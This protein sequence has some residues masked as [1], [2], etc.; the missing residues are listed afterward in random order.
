MSRHWVRSFALR[1]GSDDESFHL[2]RFAHGRGPTEEEVLAEDS[3]DGAT[4]GKFGG[5]TRAT[6]ECFTLA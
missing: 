4:D 5:E 6:S 1:C 3:K 2:Q